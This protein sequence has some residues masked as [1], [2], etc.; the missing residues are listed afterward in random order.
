VTAGVAAGSF[1]F[2]G[3]LVYA[4][5]GFSWNPVGWVALAVA[6]V[7]EIL[8]LFGFDLFG[9]GGAPVLPPGYYRHPHYVLSEFTGVPFELSPNMESTVQYVAPMGGSWTLGLGAA[10]VAEG[11]A[12]GLAVGTFGEIAVGAA[13]AY[14]IYEL[15]K[16]LVSDPGD[17]RK[18]KCED[19]YYN[20]DIPTCRGVARVRG[21]R[22]GQ[23]C[24]SSAA[25]R[26]AACL[27]GHPLP[28]L[29][30]WN[31]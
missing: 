21:K 1:A 4:G 17:D 19:N 28:P 14:G 26:F 23:A 31:N 12:E 11:A 30:I 13:A 20:V 29:N 5:I 9:G 7:L 10:T 24:Y 2:D 16:S 22:A 27:A 15:G 6:A 25:D 8:N 18:Q 3:G